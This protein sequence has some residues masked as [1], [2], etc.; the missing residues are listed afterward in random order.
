M[1]PSDK[2][3][4]VELTHDEIHELLVLID[5]HQP[6]DD[7]TTIP[8][9][10]QKLITAQESRPIRVA[11]YVTARNEPV[12]ATVFALPTRPVPA[13]RGVTRAPWGALLSEA[14]AELRVLGPGDRVTLVSD[15]SAIPELEQGASDQ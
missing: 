7:E 13:W 12:A 10:R 2:S 6:L 1:T 11:L 8:A 4:S 9:A 15:F 3:Y 14:G 5:V